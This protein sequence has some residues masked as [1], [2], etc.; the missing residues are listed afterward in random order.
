MPKVKG[1]TAL[2]KE[3]AKTEKLLKKVGYTAL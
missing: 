3:R 2:D 1:D